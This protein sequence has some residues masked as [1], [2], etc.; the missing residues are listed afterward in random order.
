MMIKQKHTKFNLCFSKLD[1]AIVSGIFFFQI[2]IVQGDKIKLRI[3][4]S[5]QALFYRV[6]NKT[7]GYHKSLFVTELQGLFKKIPRKFFLQ[8]IGSWVVDWSPL[9]PSTNWD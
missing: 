4:Y 2:F 9:A 3:V 8:A 7:T 5:L 6:L 1:K